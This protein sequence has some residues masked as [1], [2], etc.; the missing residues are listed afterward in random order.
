MSSG[1]TDRSR[2]QTDFVLRYALQIFAVV[3]ILGVFL[4]VF[5]FS[6]F[7]VATWSMLPSIWPGD[8]LVAAKWHAGRATR[9]QVMALRCPTVGEQVCLRRV[10]GLPGDRIEFQDGALWV[11]GAKALRKPVTDGVE[12]ETAEGLSWLIWPSPQMPGADTQAAIVVPPDAVYVLNDR[13]ADRSDSRD[14]GPVPIA[15]LEGKA[16]FV[17]LSLDW[18]DGDEVRTWPRVRWPRILR[19]ID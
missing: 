2:K 6:S 9:G 15:S 13:R 10:I 14:W 16:L 4:R 1:D 7:V 18:Y 11:N 12:L 3:L 19:G 5:L 17:W 8:F